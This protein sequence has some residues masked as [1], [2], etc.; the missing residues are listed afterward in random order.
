MRKLSETSISNGKE[1]SRKSVFID[2]LLKHGGTW[3]V[4]RSQS[5]TAK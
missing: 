5:A 3:V 1:S 2:V 4:V